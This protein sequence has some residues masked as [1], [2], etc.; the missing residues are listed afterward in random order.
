MDASEVPET[1]CQ[2]NDNRLTNVLEARENTQYN[3]TKIHYNTSTWTHRRCQK[4]HL[5]KRQPA[6]Q[7][8]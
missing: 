4:V 1:T 7:T 2:K 3:A 6:S 8:C 5:R